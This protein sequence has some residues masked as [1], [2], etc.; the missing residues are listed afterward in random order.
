MDPIGYFSDLVGELDEEAIYELLNALPYEDLNFEETMLPFLQITADAGR[1]DYTRIV[2]EIFS[3]NNVKEDTFPLITEIFTYDYDDDLLIFIKGCYSKIEAIDHFTNL[4]RQD[5]NSDIIRICKRI[6][7]T[8]GE[9]DYTLYISCLNAAEADNN[10]NMYLF[11]RQKVQQ[12]TTSAPPPPWMIPSNLKE[13]PLI[14]LPIFDLPPEESAAEILIRG[15]GYMGLEPQLLDYTENEFKDID[16]QN[17]PGLA[18]LV[19]NRKQ[20]NIRKAFEDKYREA[21]EAEKRELLTPIFEH[22]YQV[23]LAKDPELFKILGPINQFPFQQEWDVNDRCYKYGGCRM[24]LCQHNQ[25]EDDDGDEIELE[26]D[27]FTGNCDYCYRK[28]SSR[29]RCIRS[30]LKFGGWSN[31]YCSLLC[32]REDGNREPRNDQIDRNM[33]NEL[34]KMLEKNGIY[35]QPEHQLIPYEKRVLPEI[36]ISFRRV[37][38]PEIEQEDDF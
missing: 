32:L 34:A 30:P 24:F 26:N 28:I 16:L 15:L 2:I 25:Q 5:D 18:G 21:S 22:E 12:T 29:F 7:D 17:N 20:Q 14:E 31:N 4:I 13:I 1:K 10:Y 9:M 19:Y 35:D 23:D 33:V 11:F 27:W 38:M 3:K 37:K 36:N 6:L 8:Y